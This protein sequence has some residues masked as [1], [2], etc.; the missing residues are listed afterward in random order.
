MQPGAAIIENGME[1]PKKFKNKLS[2]DPIIPLGS[3]YPNEIKSVS[4][5]VICPS[6]FITALFSI[7]ESWK[8]PEFING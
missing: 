3:I 1:V 6:L 5:R 2:H 8:Y 4:Q 7:G